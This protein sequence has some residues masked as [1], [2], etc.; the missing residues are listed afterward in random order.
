MQYKQQYRPDL[1]LLEIGQRCSEISNLNT[2][3]SEFF[4]KLQVWTSDGLL[5]FLPL[6]L[7]VS[8][9]LPLPATVKTFLYR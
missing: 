6:P 5:I 3:N 4:T 7:T 2:M 8:I 9:F 1:G